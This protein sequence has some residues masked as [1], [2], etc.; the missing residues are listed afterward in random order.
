MATSRAGI[1]AGIRPRRAIGDRPSRAP[2]MRPPAAPVNEKAPGGGR[3]PP[4]AYRSTGRRP[5]RE[6]YARIDEYV[7]TSIMGLSAFSWRADVARH[8]RVDVPLPP[9]PAEAFMRFGAMLQSL[10]KKAG[11]TQAQLAERSRLPLRSI[12]N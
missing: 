5:G 10:R 1:G 9:V 3:A 7:N 6:K 8:R 2:I 11:M 4:G 12:Q